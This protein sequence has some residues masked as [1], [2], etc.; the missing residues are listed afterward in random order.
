V[1]TTAILIAL[2]LMISS[3]NGV[4]ADDCAPALDFEKRR[5]AGD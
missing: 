3:G 1:K 2:A 5:L 4:A